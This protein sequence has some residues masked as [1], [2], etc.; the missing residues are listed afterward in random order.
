[1]IASRGFDTYERYRPG[2]ALPEG[3][4]PLQGEELRLA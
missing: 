3:S 4:E 2:Q 1:M